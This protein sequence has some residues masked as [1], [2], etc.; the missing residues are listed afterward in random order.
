MSNLIKVQKAMKIVDSLKCYDHLGQLNQILNYYKQDV[1]FFKIIIL[2]YAET[3]SFDTN[4]KV[5]DK[6]IYHTLLKQY[7]YFFT[8]LYKNSFSSNNDPLDDFKVYT[9]MLELMKNELKIPVNLDWLFS[10]LVNSQDSKK[11]DFSF[12]NKQN[13]PIK[14]F[15]SKNVRVSVAHLIHIPIKKP[16]KILFES[17]FNNINDDKFFACLN[18]DLKVFLEKQ[19]QYLPMFIEKYIDVYKQD[20]H[21]DVALRKLSQILY[22]QILILP[23]KNKQFSKDLSKVLHKYKLMD[24]HIFNENA[25]TIINQ[26]PHFKI[27]KYLN[28]AIYACSLNKHLK[29][30]DGKIYFVLTCNKEV[31]TLNMYFSDFIDSS[32]INIPDPNSDSYFN[33]MLSCSNLPLKVLIDSF[34]NSFIQHIVDN[35]GN[36]FNQCHSV[37]KEEI[38]QISKKAS[39][40]SQL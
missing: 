17:Y 19:S 31:F 28:Q 34:V 32:K 40:L 29:G 4:K 3:S 37:I 26:Y 11:I 27:N 39:I 1:E 7:I 35:Y 15:C 14:Y 2:A 36:S 20:G 30:L 18:E 21:L 38:P 33:K 6:S 25:L 10:E 13:N 5:K 22:Q 16:S 23:I 24:N 12:I 9:E 8:D